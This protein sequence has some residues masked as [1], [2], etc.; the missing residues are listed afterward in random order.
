MRGAVGILVVL[1]MSVLSIVT[2]RYLGHLFGISD[3]LAQGSLTTAMAGVLA[4]LTLA[5]MLPL[6]PSSPIVAGSILVIGPLPT[7][8]VGFVAG[9]LAA[10]AKYMIGNLAKNDLKRVLSSRAP[11]FVR[12]METRTHIFWVVA[13]LHMIPNPAYDALGYVAGVLGIPFHLY[14]V[15]AALGGTILLSV[16][17]FA[18]PV[19]LG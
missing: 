18:G 13:V 6:S 15:G 4:V 8:V 10:V 7:F 3:G 9:C 1:A 2:R 14:F 16:F 11:Q 19:L 12:L 5:L 17:C